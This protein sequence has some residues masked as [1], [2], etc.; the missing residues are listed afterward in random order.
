[1]YGVNNTFTVDPS[2]GTALGLPTSLVQNSLTKDHKYIH[3]ESDYDISVTVVEYIPGKSSDGYLAIPTNSLGTSYLFTNDNGGIISVIALKDNTHVD[4]TVTSKN[5]LIS[6]N[7]TVKSLSLTLSKFQTRQLNC[8]AWCMG[9][10][11]A[12]SPFSV[13]YGSHNDFDR[14]FSSFT[15]SYTEEATLA[16]QA[17]VKYIV[18]M[19]SSSSRMVVLCVAKTYMKIKSNHTNS[20]LSGNY[21]YIQDFIFAQFITTNQSAI[22]SYIGHGFSVTIPPVKAYTNYYRFLTPSVTNFTHHAAIM[23]QSIDKDGV[24]LDNSHPNFVRQETVIVDSISYIVMYL[25]VTTGQH[26]ITHINPS[27]EFGVILYGF[28]VN[29]TGSYAYPGGFNFT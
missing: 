25:N 21:T 20:Q 4:I 2:T 10:V 6:G 15:T 29:G 12:S 5:Y 28:V 23:I 8:S 14:R 9:Y 24:R 1:M 22:C 26:E 17:P 7:G 13:W 18:P 3:V 16:Y 27:T 19:L 11:I